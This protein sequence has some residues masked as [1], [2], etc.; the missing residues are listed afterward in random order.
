MA[1]DEDGFLNLS[2]PQKLQLGAF[3]AGTLI[4]LLTYFVSVLL[5]GFNYV[6]HWILNNPVPILAYWSF[7]IGMLP[8]YKKVDPRELK[9]VK[10]MIHKFVT[11]GGPFILF[12]VYYQFNPPATG[13]DRVVS[14][15]SY[16]FT[17]ASITGV[18]LSSSYFK[19]KTGND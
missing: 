7:N 6:N 2:L 8:V 5:N 12:W 17:F 15:L 10:Q 1:D 11:I 18:I 13:I 9:C 16:V 3:G 19:F 14:K 4:F